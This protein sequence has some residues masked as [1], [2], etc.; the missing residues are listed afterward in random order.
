MSHVEGLDKITANLEKAMSTEIAKMNKRVE[1][2][3]D[4]VYNTIKK[5]AELTDHP[6]WMLTMM[7]SPYSTRWESNSDPHGDDG[8]VHQQTGILYRNIEKVTDIGMTKTEV[9]VGVD[10]NKTGDYIREVIEGSPKVR[11]RPFIQRGFAES[12]D[13]VK[14]ILGGGLGG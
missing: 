7:G 13:A 12:K 1:L 9:A 5:R 8:I 10:P 4:V 3:G 2:A 14:A 11:P 6:Q